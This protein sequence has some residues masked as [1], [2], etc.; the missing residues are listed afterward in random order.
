MKIAY[1]ESVLKACWASLKKGGKW[2]RLASGKFRGQ[3]EPGCNFCRSRNIRCDDCPLNFGICA[4]CIGKS[5]YNK[6]QEALGDYNDPK[7]VKAA[8][9]VRDAIAGVE[10]AFKAAKKELA[11]IKV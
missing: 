11:K 7:V 3:E 6:W 1:V 5:L 9:R 2:Q 4:K 8:R 10:R